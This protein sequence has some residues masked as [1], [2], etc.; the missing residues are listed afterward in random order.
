[1]PSARASGRSAL[2]RA[3]V[4]LVVSVVC[5]ASVR[6]ARLA[7]DGVEYH[8]MLESFWNHGTPEQR[9]GDIAT[10][11]PLLARHGYGVGDLHGG[12][13]VTQG[14]QW[15]SYHFWIYP[16]LAVPAKAVLHLIGA[17][18]FYAL[19]WTNAS[20]LVATIAWALRGRVAPSEAD[21][22]ARAR[23]GR[24]RALVR[25]VATRGG[26]RMVLRGHGARL[27]RRAALRA[28]RRGLG[29]RIA[30]PAG[31]SG[32]RSRFWARRSREPRR[33]S[34]SPSSG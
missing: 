27:D 30:R 2:V 12:F 13:F 8:S 6:E 17:D 29:A 4:V 3:L 26:L 11:T 33:S 28:R 10:L 20:L 7:G 34:I 23:D 32:W 5:V 19:A 18:E 21:R 25:A 1:M 14:G 15:Y 9:P 22:A 24:P 31:R 16:L